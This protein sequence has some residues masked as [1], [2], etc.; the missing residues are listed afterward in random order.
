MNHIDFRISPLVSNDQLNQ[1][2][3]SAWANHRDLDF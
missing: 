2:F 3:A 1:L